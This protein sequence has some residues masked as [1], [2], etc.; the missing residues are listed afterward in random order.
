MADTGWMPIET[1]PQDGSQILLWGPCMQISVGYF[2]QHSSWGE[3][4]WMLT[5]DGCMAIE[6]MSDFGVD[7]RTASPTHWQPLPSPPEPSNG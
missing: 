6:R 7:Y 3:E 2:Q 4:P 5:A 1:A